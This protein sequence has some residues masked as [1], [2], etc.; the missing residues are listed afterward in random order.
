MQLEPG[1]QVKV[2]LKRPV[3]N[4][5]AVKTLG[6]VFLKDPQIGRSRRRRPK[7]FD[8]NR[9]GGGMW[10]TIKPGSVAVPPR[11]GES[12]TLTCTVDVIRDLASVERFIDVQPA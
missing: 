6:R 12:C 8:E 11:V 4:Q 9:R 3:T 5:A 7:H 1:N 10:R 2:T